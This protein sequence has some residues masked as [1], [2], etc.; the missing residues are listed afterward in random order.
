IRLIQVVTR[1]HQRGL[2][3][4]PRAVSHQKTTAALAPASSP[5][6][7]TASA[8]PD[9][10]TGG[11]SLTPIMHWLAEQRGP[12][13]RFNQ[14]MLLQVSAGLQQDHLIIA[15]QTLIDHHDALRLRLDTGAPWSL[16]GWPLGARSAGGGL[17][18]VAIRAG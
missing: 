11:V 9:V 14:S 5:P 4:P 12:I 2:L 10:A 16:A 17:H 18:R 3:T 1:A 7:H 13:D 6:A 8:L 15:P